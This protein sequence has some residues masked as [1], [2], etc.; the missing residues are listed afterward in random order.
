MLIQITNI[1]DVSIT[2]IFDRCAV[3]LLGLQIFKDPALSL[4][5]K[6]NPCASL[7]SDLTTVSS[8]HRL[9]RMLSVIE[10][11]TYK[12]R[13][14]SSDRLKVIIE[15]NHGAKRQSVWPR[16]QSVMGHV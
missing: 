13:R 12:P 4:D 1:E 9:L 5:E 15:I 8:R 11:V 16:P 7:I 10:Q 3:G 2:D 6:V 14:R